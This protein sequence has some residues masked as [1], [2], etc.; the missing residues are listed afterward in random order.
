MLRITVEILDGG[1]ERRRKTL[2]VVDISNISELAPVSDYHVAAK[3]GEGKHLGTVF[4]VSHER[5]KGWQELVTRAFV[6]LGG[7]PK[8][9]HR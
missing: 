9:E 4:V 6:R 7:L 5:K 8:E 3:D 1:D 2:G